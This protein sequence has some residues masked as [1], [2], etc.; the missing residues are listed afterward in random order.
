MNIFMK[1]EKQINVYSNSA[2]KELK[3][4]NISVLRIV[5]MTI[6]YVLISYIIHNII[7]N[8]IFDKLLYEVY[9]FLK[10][11]DIP[12]LIN[13][14]SYFYLIVPLGVCIW[15]G[16][17]LPI[18]LITVIFVEFLRLINKRRIITM[19]KILFGSGIIFLISG[20]LMAI[21]EIYIFIN[22]Y[23]EYFMVVTCIYIIQVIIMAVLLI[24][25]SK[26]Y[27]LYKN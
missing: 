22:N 14:G 13:I 7:I 3:P 1:N 16:I 2:N 20:I 6:L 9:I 19:Q 23:I 4:E 5:F 8:I 15:I 24:K 25:E 18:L 10:Y 26:A 21:L 17:F 11:S 12:L 27:N